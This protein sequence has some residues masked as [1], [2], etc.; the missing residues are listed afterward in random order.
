MRALVVTAPDEFAVTE[1]ERPRPGPI[2][3]LCRVRTVAIC[4]TDPHI[5]Q[6]HYPGLLAEG[7]AADPRPRV[8]RRRG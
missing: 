6:G 4:G 8:V 2:E 5:I 1:V 3:V 7:L